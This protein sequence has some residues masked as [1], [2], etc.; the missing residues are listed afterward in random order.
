MLEEAHGGAGTIAQMEQSGALLSGHFALSSGLHSDKYIQCALL[1]ESPARAEEVGG[2]LA[3]LVEEAVGCG[4]I[5]AVASPALGGIVIGHEVARALGARSVFAERSSGTLSLRRGF[6]LKPYERVLVV[7]DVVTT[8]LST[9]EV[10]DLV[11][12]EGAD[13]VAVA[14]IVDRSGGV[15]FGIPFVYLVRAAISNYDPAECPLCKKGLPVVKPGS[16]RD[17]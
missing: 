14:S 17:T 13:P 7:E 9:R 10:M 15:D 1:L 8:G 16:R 6:R 2:A 4:T 12:A 5:G 3:V 11:K